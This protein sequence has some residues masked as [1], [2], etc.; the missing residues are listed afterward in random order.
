MSKTFEETF[1]ECV[2]V[3]RREFIIFG[4]EAFTFTNIQLQTIAILVRGG[5]TARD[6]GHAI[7]SNLMEYVDD[8]EQWRD[9][10]MD[11]ILRRADINLEIV[12]AQK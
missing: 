11:A 8:D 4:A 2:N 1:D 9:V 7:S 5:V 3:L 6:F 12:E 10:F